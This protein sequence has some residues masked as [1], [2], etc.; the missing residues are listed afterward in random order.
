MFFCVP[1]MAIFFLCNRQTTIE[2]ASR[3]HDHELALADQQNGPGG[4][5]L[6]KLVVSCLVCGL[7]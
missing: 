2:F 6:G 4:K 3:P 5:E 7:N 1:T